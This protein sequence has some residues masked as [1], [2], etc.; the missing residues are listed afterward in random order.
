MTGAGCNVPRT[1][2]EKYS[3]NLCTL[4]VADIRITCKVKG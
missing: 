3:E 4:N 1:G 2:I